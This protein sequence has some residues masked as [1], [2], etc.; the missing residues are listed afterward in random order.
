VVEPEIVL[1][2]DQILIASA[3]TFVFKTKIDPAFVPQAIVCSWAGYYEPTKGLLRSSD[4]SSD[5]DFAVCA[6]PQLALQSQTPLSLTLS[7]LLI[8]P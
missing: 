7:Q 5:Y 1:L 2:H 3:L 6:M 8:T 4:F